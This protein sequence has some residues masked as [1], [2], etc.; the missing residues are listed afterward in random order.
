MQ[1]IKSNVKYYPWQTDLIRGVLQHQRNSIHVV[2]SS[3]QKGKSVVAE[4]IILKFAIV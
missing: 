3:R 4:T 2:K 1:V